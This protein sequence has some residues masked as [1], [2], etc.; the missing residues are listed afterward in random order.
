[1]EKSKKCDKYLRRKMYAELN[2]D[3]YGKQIRRLIE[4]FIKFN[5]YTEYYLNK[6]KPNRKKSMSVIDDVE[7]WEK[8][9]QHLKIKYLKDFKKF[10]LCKRTKEFV[11]KWFVFNIKIRLPW[12]FTLSST[13]MDKSWILIQLI[14]G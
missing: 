12:T 9:V 13:N 2:N 7:G 5:R 14:Y 10:Y 8:A 3:V 4:R 11:R 6:L 1:M